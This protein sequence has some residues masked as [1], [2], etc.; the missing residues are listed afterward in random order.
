MVLYQSV[1]SHRFYQCYKGNEMSNEC[2]LCGVKDNTE[3]KNSEL[4]PNDFY[5]HGDIEE[6]YDMGE[7]SC[8]CKECFGKGN[9]YE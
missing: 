5:W 6:D 2:E 9:Y 4:Y 7:H 1:V 8:L 3:D